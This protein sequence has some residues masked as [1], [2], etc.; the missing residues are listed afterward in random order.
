MLRPKSPGGGDDRVSGTDAE[1]HDD[2]YHN[3]SS[4]FCCNADRAEMADLRLCIGGATGPTDKITAVIGDPPKRF[5]VTE[6]ENIDKAQAS[7]K[8]S[9]REAIAPQTKKTN[10]MP[11]A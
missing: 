4:G 3:G 2:I 8:S 6:C 7:L 5:G 9:G 10:M 11:I 1:R